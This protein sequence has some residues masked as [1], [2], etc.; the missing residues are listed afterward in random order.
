MVV[1]FRNMGYN[2]K[3]SEMIVIGLG[4]GR[5]HLAHLQICKYFMDDSSVNF[6]TRFFFIFRQIFAKY[7]E[8]PCAVIHKVLTDP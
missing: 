6:Q 8:K 2:L 4:L 3:N 5:I 1:D 7:D